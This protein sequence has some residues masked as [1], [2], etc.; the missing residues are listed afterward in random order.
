MKLPNV[1]TKCIG[2]SNPW[3]SPNGCLPYLNVSTPHDDGQSITIAG[4]ENIVHH[5]NQ[6]AVHNRS[7]AARIYSKFNFS[8]PQD[9]YQIEPDDPASYAYMQYLQNNLHDCLQYYLWGDPQQSENTRMMYAKRTPLFFNFYYPSRYIKRTE[10]LLK[11]TQGFSIEDKIE[12]HNVENVIVEQITDEFNYYYCTFFLFRP[13]DVIRRKKMSKC[14][15]IAIENGWWLFEWPPLR[16]GRRHP[17]RL[18]CN[19]DP[20]AGA[21]QRATKPS[22]GMSKING[23]SAKNSDRLSVERCGRNVCDARTGN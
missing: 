9:F 11:L 2:D 7:I 15:G 20:N 3:R 13:S 8:F 12:N 19:G 17:V 5:F 22:A 6:N 21:N 14:A 23:I 10:N 4:Y 16:R 18:H 1:P